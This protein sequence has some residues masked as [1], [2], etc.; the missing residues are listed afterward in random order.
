MCRVLKTQHNK[1]S[2][3]QYDNENLDNDLNELETLIKKIQEITKKNGFRNWL[4]GFDDT[5]K[6]TS[7]DELKN[8]ESGIEAYFKMKKVLDTKY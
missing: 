4:S 8:F 7:L 6:A 1:S 2:A 5:H 3:D